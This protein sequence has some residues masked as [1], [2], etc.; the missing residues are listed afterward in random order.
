VF[1]YT[2]KGY[3]GANPE[4]SEIFSWAQKNKVAFYPVTASSPEPSAAYAKSQKL[5]FMFYSADQ[6]M[7]MTLARY[8]PTLYLFKDA[9]VVDKWSGRNLPSIQKLQ[10]ITSK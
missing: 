8:N 3:N 4:I 9:V 7:L 6:K 2:D 1:T 10:K 5:P